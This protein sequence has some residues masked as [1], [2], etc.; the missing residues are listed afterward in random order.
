MKF[1][2]PKITQTPHR[3]SLLLCHLRTHL[4]F[5]IRAY[6]ERSSLKALEKSTMCVIYNFNK[7]LYIFS[8]NSPHFWLVYDRN[9]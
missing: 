7:K 8:N 4:H 5:I 3:V 6:Y 9:N 2:V 1:F